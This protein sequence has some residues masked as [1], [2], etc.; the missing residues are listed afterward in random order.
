MSFQRF[1]SFYL[2]PLCV[3]L[4]Q[5]VQSMV[6][7][8]SIPNNSGS[9]MVPPCGHSSFNLSF[10]TYYLA[11]HLKNQANFPILCLCDSLFFVGAVCIPR[12]FVMVCSNLYRFQ[13]FSHFLLH[14]Y[15]LEGCE[16]YCPM[17]FTSLFSVYT[18]THTQLSRT[19]ISAGLL[20]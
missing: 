11:A 7:F 14:N 12:P 17:S 15:K 1:L 3:S 5:L 6:K 16:V 4:Y 8:P 2:L 19:R 18:H 9:K 10:I 20:S 13:L